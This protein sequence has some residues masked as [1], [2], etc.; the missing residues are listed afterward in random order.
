MKRTAFLYI[1]NMKNYLVLVFHY[2]KTILI[3]K[4]WQNLKHQ[5]LNWLIYLLINNWRRNPRQLWVQQWLPALS[6]RPVRISV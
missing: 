6:R 5:I 2:M 1:S 3:F 4:I